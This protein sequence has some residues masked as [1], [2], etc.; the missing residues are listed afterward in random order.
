MSIKPSIDAAKAYIYSMNLSMII[1]KMV[2]QGWLER[3]A[4][5]ISKLY[6]NFLW[7]QRKYGQKHDIVPTEEIDEFWHNHILDTRKY[8]EDCQKIFGFYLDHYPYFGIDEK[9]DMGDLYAAFDNTLALYKEEFG[10]NAFAS[11]IRTPFSIIWEK[12]KP[13]MPIRKKVLPTEL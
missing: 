10:D 11:K 6:K 8:K 1:E 3:D 9:S 13:K 7:L 12:I 2:F 5:T 4:I